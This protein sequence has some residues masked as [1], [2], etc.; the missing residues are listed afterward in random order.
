M[1]NKNK[2]WTPTKII[3]TVLII[4]VLFFI[5]FKLGIFN[6]LLDNFLTSSVASDAPS[7]GAISNGGGGVR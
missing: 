1:G 4:S 5:L 2:F 7:V 6:T 3:V